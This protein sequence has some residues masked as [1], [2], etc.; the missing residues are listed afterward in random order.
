MLALVGREC[1]R[2][3]AAIPEGHRVEHKLALELAFTVE[4]LNAIVAAI[5]DINQ[6]VPGENHT[7]D[8]PV[9]A[10]T[11]GIWR[12]RRW[13]VVI[14]RVAIGTPGLDKGPSAGIELHHAPIEVAVGNVDFFPG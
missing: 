5:A 10:G 7:V 14:G 6:A 13:F 9:E 2:P 12:L 1:N 4:D 11:L 3:D 8:G